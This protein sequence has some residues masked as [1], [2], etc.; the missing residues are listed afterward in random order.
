VNPW[1]VVVA[2]VGWAL[3]LVVLAWVAVQGA[4]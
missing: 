2:V 3:L 4:W 1:A